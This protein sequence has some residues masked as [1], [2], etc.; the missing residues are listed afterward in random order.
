MNSK[1]YVKEITSFLCKVYVNPDQRIDIQLEVEDLKLD[2]D[3]SIASGL[4]INELLTNALKYAFP[5]SKSDRVHILFKQDE[6]KQAVLIVSDNGKGL[7]HNINIDAVETLG[8]KIVQ[9]LAQDQLDGTFEIEQGDE[10]LTFCI[11][12][13]LTDEEE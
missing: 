5:H 2:L 4:I 6:M 12:F 11:G 1:E 3:K 8:L 7:S 9:M 13:P 10:S